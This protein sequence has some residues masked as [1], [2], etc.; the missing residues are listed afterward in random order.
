M[1]EDALPVV[2][3][4]V[5]DKHTPMAM[6]QKPRKS[7]SP[8]QQKRLLRI[9]FGIFI[10]VL[11]WLVFA[12]GRG[13]FYLQQQKKYLA[14]LEAEQEILVQQNK[15]MKQNVE[16]LQS[17]KEYLEQLARDEHG[18]LKDNEIVFD[19]AKKKKE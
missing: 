5:T 6:K 15:E 18:M 8:I 16:R 19:F 12:P 17:D 1:D 14:S 13:I 3:Y 7:L 2:T 10:L 11:L 9:S 4:D